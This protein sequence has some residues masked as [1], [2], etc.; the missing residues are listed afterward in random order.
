M[1]AEGDMVSVRFT[2]EGTHQG[3]FGG[4]EPTGNR[5][6]GSNIGHFRIEDGRIVERW[7]ESDN[8][9][10]LQQLDAVQR[11]AK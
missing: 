4:I 3:R 8:P 9:A 2:F 5:G 11:P 10:L 6:S 1:I 7:L